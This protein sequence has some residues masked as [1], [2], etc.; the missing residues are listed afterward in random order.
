MK[1]R[2]PVLLGPP[3]VWKELTIDF[4]FLG[5]VQIVFCRRGRRWFFPD[6]AFTNLNTD[7]GPLSVRGGL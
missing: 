3:I 1:V 5:R 2:K 4:R 7:A 6:S